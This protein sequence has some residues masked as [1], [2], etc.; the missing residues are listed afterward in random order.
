M[1]LKN[2][3]DKSIEQLKHIERLSRQTRHHQI[4]LNQIY[5]QKLS[6]E[7]KN[8]KNQYEQTFL[9]SNI[10]Q[11]LEEQRKEI[12]HITINQIANEREHHSLSNPIPEIIEN[13]PLSSNELPRSSC[14]L[15]SKDCQL[16]PCQPI[17]HYKSFIKKEH[18]KTLRERN[19]SNKNSDLNSNVSHF[20]NLLTNLQ[21]TKYQKNRRQLTAT[22]SNQNRLANRYISMERTKTRLDEQSRLLH[23][24]LYDKKKFAY[25]KEDQYEIKQAIKRHLEI[26]AKFCA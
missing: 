15:F 4:H 25:V 8:L 13:R 19:P 24:R 1:I 17:Y 3:M 9:R 18:D 22:I 11:K 5:D 26:S 6:R 21:Q 14:H 12:L 16:Y 23:E 2:P 7:L 10:D 20:Q